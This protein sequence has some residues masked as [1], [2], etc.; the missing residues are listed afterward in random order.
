[1]RK[2]NCAPSLRPI[3]LRCIVRV[4]SGQPSSFVEIVEQPI[5]VRGDLQEPLREVAPLDEMRAAPAAPVDDLLVREHGPIVRAPV[6]RRLALVRETAL[7]EAQEEPLIPAVILGLAGRDL[8]RPIVARSHQADLA[9]HVAGCSRSVQAAGS[10][11]RSI[12]AFS[13]GS[14]NASQ[15]IG[16][17]TL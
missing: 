2:A 3:Q 12:A 17:S 4:R 7:E 5:G 11:P 14:P 8:A 10:I 13:A 1:M 9:A 15:P 6:H 16:W